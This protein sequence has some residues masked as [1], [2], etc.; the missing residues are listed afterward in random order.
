[1]LRELQKEIGFRYIKFHGLLDDDMMVY[2]EA[3][4]GTVELSFTYIDMVF[5]FLLSINLKPL[6]QLSF[7]PKVLAKNPERTMFYR[8][9]IISLPKDMD[10]W[11]YLIEKL[12]LHLQTR[13]GIK[14]VESWPFCLW[15]LP[16][17]PLTMFGFE[18][19]EEFFQFY[20]ET[21]FTVK[22]CNPNIIFG[23]PS[24][25]YS[26]LEKGEW[27][28]AFMDFCKENDCIPKFLNFNFYPLTLEE[29]PSLSLQ[30]ILSLF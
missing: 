16:E 30:K 25:M 1:M 7:M 14:E 10:K 23:S 26:S 19:N 6:M 28:E 15:N 17:S 3:P 5:D 18:N 11:N 21:Y 8:E 29:N 2:S 27:V 13:Y 22:K 4:D 20:K 12:V 9:S 24:F